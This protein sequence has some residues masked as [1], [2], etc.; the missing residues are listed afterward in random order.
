VGLVATAHASVQTT[1]SFDHITAIHSAPPSTTWTQQNLGSAVGNV[2]GDSTATTI[3]ATGGDIYGS[4]DSGVFYH[5]GWTGDGTFIVRTGALNR[6]H[7]WAKAGI[8]LRASLAPYA[9]N[10]FLAVTPTQGTVLQGRYG[11]GTSGYGT[12]TRGQYWTA[13]PGSWL[14]LVRGGGSI[15]AFWSPEGINWYPIAS[16]E[17]VLPQTIFVGLA[18]SSHNP[19]AAATTTFSNFAIE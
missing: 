15:A 17:D 7:D 8:M 18:V 2:S 12:V 4:S 1:A 11:N 6:T 3:Q 5:R 13:G 19:S 14:K 10:T 9:A 16:M